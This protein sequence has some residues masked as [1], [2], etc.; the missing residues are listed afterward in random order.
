MGFYPFDPIYGNYQLCSP[1]F[2][3]VTLQLEGKKKLEIICRKK[4]ID[5][6]YI[7]TVMWN[8]KLQDK[9][10]IFYSDM[11]K[12]GKLEIELIPNHP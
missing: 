1:L 4:T 7:R 5:A 8:G 3:K 10:F 11:M 6:G 12:G 2:D 9:N